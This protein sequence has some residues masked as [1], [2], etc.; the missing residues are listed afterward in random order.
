M[1]RWNPGE[2]P[3]HAPRLVMWLIVVVVL[4]FQ[5]PWP[6]IA[7]MP[8]PMVQVTPG[9]YVFRGADEEAT[10][11]NAGGI[12]NIGFIVGE[13]SVAVID[14]GGSPMMGRALLAAIRQVTELPIGY[15]IN[16]HF[17]PDHIFGNAAFVDEAPV[18]VGHVN[19]PPALGARQENYLA[20]ARDAFG[21][22][23]SASWFVAPQRLIAGRETIDLGG[24]RLVLEAYPPAH[25]DSDLTILDETTQTLFA[26][27]LVFLER[28]PAIDGSITGWLGAL[29]QL[30]QV[31]A[32]QV[33]P[34]H[35][36]VT[37]PWPAALENE[38]RYLTLIVR[39]TREILAKGGTLQ[40]ATG[41]VG[42]SEKARWLLFD[43]Y[44]AR[45]V[46]AAYTELEWE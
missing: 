39:E 13:E 25:T 43:T 23:V 42:L 6:A 4:S 34:G 16:T 21:S 24:R 17:H 3:D 26:G 46:T 15:V 1:I 7:E 28:I 29:D 10:S 8:L 9:V 35:G 18:F 41:A 37:A 44:N 27:D 45:N 20:H 11:E 19:L 32:R 5:Q 14:T 31:A 2:S 33:V 38:Q 30:R 12:A 22:D 40:E 36:P